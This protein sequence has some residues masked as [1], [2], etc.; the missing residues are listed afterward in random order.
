MA[1]TKKADAP[2][3]TATKKKA[4]PKKVVEEIV[5]ETS[6]MTPEE[7]AQAAMQERIGKCN[8]EVAAVLQKYNCDLEA[9]MLLQPGMV[10]P[11]IRIVPVEILQ[12]RQQQ[13]RQQMA[14]QEPS[15]I[16]QP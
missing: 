9:N 4:A 2:K 1:R 11:Q 10:I 6:Q 8:E 13:Q 7:Q 3:S 16:I 14:P 5:E 12:Q 15:P